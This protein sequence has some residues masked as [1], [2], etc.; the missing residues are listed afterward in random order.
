MFDYVVGGALETQI[1]LVNL[2]CIPVHVWGSRASIPTSRI[3]WY[4]IWIRPRANSRTLLKAGL[5]VKGALDE[6][7]LVSF[8]ED[9]RKP[10]LARFRA[11]CGWVPD[12]DEV[13]SF[14]SELCGTRWRRRIRRTSPWSSGLSARKKRVYLDSFRN[15]F[16]ATVVAPYSVRR[17]RE[18]AP[19][20]M[21][22]ALGGGEDVARSR[23]FNLGNYEKRLAGADPWDGFLRAAASRLKAAAKALPRA[24][25]SPLF[26]E[27]CG[28][29]RITEPITLAPS[30]SSTQVRSECGDAVA[31]NNGA[32]WRSAG[33]PPRKSGD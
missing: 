20:S 28:C 27:T 31:A 32:P 18:K 16:G 4:S 29:P 2:G 23:E 1:A 19:F 9:V 30:A 33:L 5:L 10:G 24:L 11:A 7:G 15:G 12:F 3:G 22:L 14:A 8:P 26:L 13:R 21:P 17:R 6:L 25:S